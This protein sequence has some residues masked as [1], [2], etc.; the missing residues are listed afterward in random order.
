VALEFGLGLRKTVEVIDQDVGVEQ[1]FYHSVR[2]L[3]AEPFLIGQAILSV[4]PPQAECVLN[5]HFGI[6]HRVAR[7]IVVDCLPDQ[8]GA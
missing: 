3:G 5:S 8:R 2:P 4:R 6:G 7:D 1:R